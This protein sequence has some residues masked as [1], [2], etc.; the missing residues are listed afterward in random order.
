MKRK[1]LTKA[2]ISIA[3]AQIGRDGGRI[4]GK[5][6]SPAKQRAARMNGNWRA[7]LK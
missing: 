3:M 6:R 5:S 1:K 7:K 4:G 2:Q